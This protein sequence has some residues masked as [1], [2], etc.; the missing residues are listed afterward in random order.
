MKRLFL[1]ILGFIAFNSILNA[2]VY[3]Y[4]TKCPQWEHGQI[5]YYDG[6]QQNIN[7]SIPPL[8]FC[9]DA[10]RIE[11]M[12]KYDGDFYEYEELLT[13]NQTFFNWYGYYIHPFYGEEYIGL[14]VRVVV[15]GHEQKT[16]IVRLNTTSGLLVQRNDILSPS[17]NIW[18]GY[19]Y[20]FFIRK[21]P[22][23]EFTGN[24]NDLSMSGEL[25][26]YNGSNINEL[27]DYVY[28]K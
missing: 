21:I 1:I 13:S 10:T 22:L 5:V 20:I 9:W 7:G 16:P 11:G 28:I 12:I 18:N 25:K 4:Q 19:E 26:I 24:L 27:K 15:M 8:Q 17:G 14:F 3:P 2:A 6:I 23:D